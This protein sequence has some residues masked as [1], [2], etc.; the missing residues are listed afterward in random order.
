VWKKRKGFQGGK[1]WEHNGESRRDNDTEN[2]IAHG[3]P[4]KLFE[5]D[6]KE[7]ERIRNSS[8]SHKSELRKYQDSS[9]AKAPLSEAFSARLKAV[10][11]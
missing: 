9:G 6:A 2:L 8:P 3:M 11:S 5:R 4:T 10:P 1:R 7:I